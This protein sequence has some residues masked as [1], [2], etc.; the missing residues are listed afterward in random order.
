ME[1]GIEAARGEARAQPA[2]RVVQRLVERAARGLKA[3]GEDV[4]RHVVEGD[5]DEHLALVGRE[6]LGDRLADGASSSAIWASWCGEEP[7]S[8]KAGQPAGSSV[9]SRSFHARRRIFTPASSSAN[10]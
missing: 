8:A 10:L 2:A 9:T 3:L 7:G 1:V 5:G 4:D 6:V